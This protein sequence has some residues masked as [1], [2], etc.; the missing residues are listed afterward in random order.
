MTLLVK[1]KYWCVFL[2][3]LYCNFW[4]YQQRPLLHSWNVCMAIALLG[5]LHGDCTVTIHRSRSAFMKP[6]SFLDI[7]ICKPTLKVSRMAFSL[8]AFK[9]I[10]QK[11]VE[12]VVKLRVQ[13]LTSWNLSQAQK[14]KWLHIVTALPTQKVP[15]K[16]SFG[17]YCLPATARRISKVWLNPLF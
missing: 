10:G 3:F 11:E 14:S 15:P 2:L 4:I 17:L 9:C 16:L 8:K 1:A 5:H 7:F 12:R 13:H 6:L